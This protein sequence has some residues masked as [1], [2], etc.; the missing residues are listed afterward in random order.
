MDHLRWMLVLS[1]IR[2]MR[3]GA[4]VPVV[5][6]RTITLTEIDGE[7]SGLVQADVRRRTGSQE[8][9]PIVL[10]AFSDPRLVSRRYENCTLATALWDAG[11]AL[12][13]THAALS[14][15]GIGSCIVSSAIS[16]ELESGL[17]ASLVSCVHVGSLMAGEL[18]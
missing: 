4:F 17:P 14:A 11:A 13:Q 6:G 15:Q 7:I 9:P 8:A 12:G 10:A 16:G 5:Q 1:N 3:D 2:G 18:A